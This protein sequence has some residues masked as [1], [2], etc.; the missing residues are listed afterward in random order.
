MCA[1]TGAHANTSEG[2]ASHAT[3]WSC[4]IVLVVLSCDQQARSHAGQ[5]IMSDRGI[6]NATEEGTR[7]TAGC[8]HSK[9]KGAVY[10]CVHTTC[11][12]SVP[13][14]TTAPRRASLTSTLYQGDAL[15]T[16]VLSYV[17]KVV[18][19]TAGQQF[20]DSSAKLPCAAREPAFEVR[21]APIGRPGPH[22]FQPTVN[23]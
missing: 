16:A 19:T 4:A 10:R 21:R 11:N 8:E 6:H 22:C 23:D 2:R 12:T 13:V 14:I 5:S 3:I 1:P 15:C 9:P 7:N 17:M 20:S 18:S